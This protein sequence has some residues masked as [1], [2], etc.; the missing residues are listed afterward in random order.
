MYLTYYSMH[1]VA[2]AV[3]ARCVINTPQYFLMR[4]DEAETSDASRA[5]CSIINA[6]HA[7]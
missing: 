4:A 1:I 2:K 7:H 5:P 6:E 3:T